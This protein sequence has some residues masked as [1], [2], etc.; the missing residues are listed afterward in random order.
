MS[1]DNLVPSIAYELQVILYE[2]N[3]S[4]HFEKSINT[5]DANTTMTPFKICLPLWKSMGVL[6]HVAIALVA[7]GR[8]Q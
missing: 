3:I 1:V 7:L 8:C 5:E 6:C 4:I 2:R